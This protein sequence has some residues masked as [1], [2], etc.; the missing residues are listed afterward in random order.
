M[1]MQPKQVVIVGAGIAG[2]SAAYAVQQR[3][4]EKNLPVT[5]TIVDAASYVG[6]KILTHH[7]ND[8]VIEAG[9]DSFLSQKPW[10]LELCRKLGLSD[11]IINTN[12]TEKKAFVYSKGQLRELPEGLVVI[13]PSNVGAFL[14]NGLVSLP[15]LLRMAG[16]YVLPVNR[17]DKDESLA[18][19]FSRRL[20]REAFDRFIEPLMAGIYAG[21]AQ[22]MS[23]RATFPRFYDMEQ[24]QGSLIRGM[25][26]G[27][28][29]VGSLGGTSQPTHTLFVT[30]RDGL[31]TLVDAM[32]S[33][34]KQGGCHL[35]L[36]TPVKTVR[37]LRRGAD[38]PEVTGEQGGPQSE[39]SY[40]VLL[41][42][43][44]SLPADVVVMATPAFVTADC[45]KGLDRL[46]AEQ[47]HSIPYASTATVALVYERS[48][49]SKAVQGFGFVV[50]RI[51]ER[52]ILA[53]TWASNKWSHRAPSNHLLVRCYL[54]GVGREEVLQR[55]NE[56]LAWLAQE[57][58][59]DLVGLS[60]KPLYTEVNR[61]NRGMPQYT[62]GH[63]DRVAE[64]KQGLAKYPGVVVT[65]AAYHGIGIPD[66]IRDGTETAQSILS[67][68]EPD[69]RKE[70][71][72]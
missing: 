65:G 47:F 10:A 38:I 48:L 49:L 5:C 16:D 36:G 26:K 72:S 20:G 57:D 40:Q 35:L 17:S 67:M 63:L 39:A 11:Q 30:L 69:H 23:L 60:A 32:V 68:L 61:W 54:G 37:A 71:L 31:G 29:P 15:G 22:Q 44:E 27:K 14:K 59:H 45:L 53:A 6:G 56:T 7:I 12:P 24:Q 64:I 41:E 51:E 58:L 66:C 2:L 43:G 42:S 9:P 55:D 28:K 70:A 3:A 33:A 4:R 19:F 18:S 1:T 25:M 21:D 50:P 52:R 46:L 8:Y 62:I 34:L 13:R